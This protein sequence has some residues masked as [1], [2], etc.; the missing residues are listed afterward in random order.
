MPEGDTIAGLALRLAPALSGRVIR[1]CEAQALDPAGLIGRRVE[2]VRSHGKHLMVDVDGGLTLLV[3]LG[4]LGR[5]RVLRAPLRERRTTPQLLLEVDG[6]RVLFSRV[7][8]LR[9]VARQAAARVVGALGPD[10]AGEAFDLDEATRRLR[11]SA[12][13]T[14]AEALLDQ[15]AMAG[16]GNELKSEILFLERQSP[17]ARVADVDDAR[18][19]AIVSR[20]R[21]LVVANVGRARVTRNALRGPRVWVYGRAGRACLR[22]GGVIEKI[23]QGRDVPRSTFFCATCQPSPRPVAP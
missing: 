13:P 19:R 6:A 23:T 20:A 1:A 4:M 17:R 11:A 15:G 9:L 18:L 5:V 16:V 3:H 14:I 2:A 8:V 12:R 22:C 7:P 10:L 21:A